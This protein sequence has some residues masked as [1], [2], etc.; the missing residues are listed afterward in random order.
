M[1]SIMKILFVSCYV[2]N[3]F[4]MDITKQ[5][6]E[7][8]IINCDFDYI[9]LNDAP[10]DPKDDYLGLVDILTGKENC[11]QIIKETAKRNNFIHIAIP[12][13]IHYKTKKLPNQGGPRHI[14]N[15]NWFN[16]H[17][18]SLV[19]NLHEYDFLCYIDSDAFF[20]KPVDLNEL[21]D[22]DIIGPLIRIRRMK[23]PHTGLFFINLKTVRN[24]KEIRWDNTLKTD[25]GSK[26]AQ[27]LKFNSGYRLKSL[28]CYN[29]Y[30]FGNWM[31]NTHTIAQLNMPELSEIL[32]KYPKEIPIDTRHFVPYHEKIRFIDTWY[33]HSVIHLRAGSTF[34]L[35]CKA[36]RNMTKP[37][38][39]KEHEVYFYKLESFIEEFNLDINLAQTLLQ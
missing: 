4:F 17:I 3:G 30:S 33:N 39:Q 8:N 15:F 12:Q 6:L 31:T 11:H 28:G 16:S 18:N 35:G 36:H 37:Q 10:E 2:N 14:D 21:K 27:F 22:F 20:V 9:C 38:I 13:K 26:I 1:L 32:S 19:P 7:K 29:G 24:F 25:T 23:Y 34:S 5:T